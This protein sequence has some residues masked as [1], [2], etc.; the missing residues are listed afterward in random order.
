MPPKKRVKK[1]RV[2]KPVKKGLKQKQKQQQKVNVSV[3]AGGSGGGGTQFIPMPQAPTF[4]Y[5]QLANLIRPANT[6]DIPIRAQAN[7]EPLP[8]RAGEEASLASSIPSSIASSMPSSMAS[9]GS[10]SPFASAHPGYVSDL[11]S[12][13]AEADKESFRRQERRNVEMLRKYGSSAP[14]GYFDDSESSGTP[15]IELGKAT[16]SFL[17]KKLSSKTPRSD[18]GKARGS[19]KDKYVNVGRNMQNEFAMGGGSSA[20]VGGS[21]AS[22][23]GSEPTS[24]QTSLTNGSADIF[25]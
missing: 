17:E 18:K 1:S 21:S 24:L 25:V 20:S 5:A 11:T 8:A 3:S 14:R 10:F 23:S 9:S 22:V 6:V 19:T 13:G 4:D 12:S 7:P 2:K 15:S 16:T